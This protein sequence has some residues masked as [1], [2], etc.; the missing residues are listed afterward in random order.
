VADIV[1]LVVDGPDVYDELTMTTS[2][3][4]T[5]VLYNGTTGHAG[6][7][8]LGRMSAPDEDN[9][10]QTEFNAADIRWTQDGLAPGGFQ[11]NTLIHEFGHGHGLAHPHDTG[12]RSSIMREVVQETPTSLF[13]YTRGQFDLNQG[14]HTMMSYEDGWETS[15]FGQADTTDPYGWVK[16]LMAF[17]IDGIQDKYGVNEE[18]ATGN[19]TY[20]LRDDNVGALFDADHNILRQATQFQCIWDAG[21]TDAIT[22]SGARDCTI[23]LRPATLRYEVGGGGWMSFA[24]GVHGG[25]TIANGVTI[26]NAQSGSGADALTGN[27]AANRLE[28]GAGDDSLSGGGG[29]DL[30]IGGLG[31][32]RMDGG[33]GSDLFLIGSDD[34]GIGLARDVIAGF[35]QGIDRI[36][37]S[38]TGASRFIGT[39]DFSGGAGQV[40]F[41]A[42]AGTTLIEVDQN[43]DRLT[44]FQIELDSGVQLSLDDFVGL[45]DANGATA[46]SDVINGTS[47]SEVLRGYGGNDVINGNGGNDQLIG[48]AGADRL[49]GGAGR[50]FF[51]LESVSDS[52][53]GGADTITDFTRKWDRIDLSGIDAIAGTP[54]NDAFQFIGK[55]AFSGQ[56]SELRYVNSNGMTII[57]GDVNGDAVADFQVVLDD[58]MTLATTDFIF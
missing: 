2:S 15:P 30:L 48:G 11:F 35:E 45:A 31:A 21:G 1:Y 3:D 23:D 4:F 54:A 13:N 18:W 32:D 37:L 40:R 24:W 26:E 16:G 42:V 50:D 7:S 36:D 57:S 43:G 9:E 29:N 8:L 20:V 39:S 49:T 33:G 25:Y 58:K 56:A 6:P 41:V 34:S 5:L 46:G 28:A 51:V 53:V 55:N 19:D 52:P 10:G 22:Y 44:D 17:D 14:V 12:G 27:E 47:A 38:G